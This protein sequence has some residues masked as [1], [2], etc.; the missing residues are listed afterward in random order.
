AAPEI[1]VVAGLATAEAAAEWV[2][3]AAIKW[4]NDVVIDGR[5]LAGILSEMESD[6]DRVRYVLLG[7]GVNLNSTP[8]DFPPEVRDKAVSL[9][10]A[11]GR[12]IDRAVFTERL[13]SRLEERYDRYVSAGFAALRPIWE[14][15]SDL[16]GRHVRIEDGARSYEGD[17]LGLADDGTLMLRDAA[18]MEMR[19]IAGDVTVIGGYTGAAPLRTG[20][21]H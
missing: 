20:A 9:F 1:A 21:E 12:P 2:P 3:Q 17:V 7:I 8:D 14:A 13:L 4:P 5:K 18:G 6:Q 10:S 19:V 15:R 11:S 16:H